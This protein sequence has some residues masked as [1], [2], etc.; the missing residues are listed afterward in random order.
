VCLAL[1]DT[2]HDN[3]WISFL[4]VGRN[5][6]I[7]DDYSCIITVIITFGWSSSEVIFKTIAAIKEFTNVAPNVDLENKVAS[8]M[9]KHK[10]TNIKDHFV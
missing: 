5:N 3:L 6:Q 9:L 4:L 2:T 8:R 1:I 10:V 7:V